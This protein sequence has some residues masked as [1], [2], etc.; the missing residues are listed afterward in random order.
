MFTFNLLKKDS[1]TDAR[2]GKIHT[3]HGEINT[4][5]FIPVGTQATIKA[6]TP[7]DLK[8]LGAEIILC[9]TYHLFLRP[10][11]ELIK[12]LGGLHR[13]MH[14]DYPL[15]TDSGGFQVY[16][17]S[18]NQKVSEEGIAFKSHLDGS[19]HFLTPELCMEI[20]EA[21]GADV[22]MCLDE[23]VPYP[24]SYEY[25]HDSLKRTTRWA[26]RCQKSKK[27]ESQALFGI[28]QGGMF[29]DLREQSARELVNLNFDGYAIGGLSVG[30]STSLMREMVEHSAALLPREKPRYLMGVG[31]PED[32]VESVKR[33]IDM[34]DCVLPTRNARN[35]MLFT[36]FGKIAIKNARHRS[37]DIPIDPHCT[38]Y[39]CTHYSRAYLHHLFSAKEILSSRL[40]TIHNLFYYLS[41]IKELRM[42]ILEG[43][44][45]HFY[46]NFY[47]SRNIQASEELTGSSK[48]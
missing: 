27:R 3:N 35:G 17:I 47:E 44:F 14:W 23:C 6:L 36:S 24:S 4:P 2:L 46:Q 43:R 39:T 7:E 15:L 21:L 13:F 32:I 18:A 10:G 1:A 38:C 11:H 5:A 42:A 45:D 25:V 20:Q 26:K 22:A 33:G 12:S 16:S 37:E 28:V 40:N 48:L 9:N 41:L 30:E 34:F 8:G 31:T 19:R 29:K